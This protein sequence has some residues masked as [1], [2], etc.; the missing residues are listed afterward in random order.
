MFGRRLRA[1]VE[2]LE[3][4]VWN[5]RTGA[6]SVKTNEIYISQARRTLDALLDHFGLEVE[7]VPSQPAK[8][9]V[10]AREGA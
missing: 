1:K 9:V 2:E 4:E 3:R 6:A 5:L 10:K 7:E 8:R